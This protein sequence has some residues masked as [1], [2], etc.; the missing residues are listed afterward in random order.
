MSVNY[1]LEF[2]SSNGPNLTLSL[3]LEEPTLEPKV[4]TRGMVYL[5]VRT[6]V[7]QPLVSDKKY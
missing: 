4:E 2:P 5:W 3:S 1:E 7:G 6:K